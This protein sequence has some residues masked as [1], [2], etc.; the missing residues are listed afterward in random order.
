MERID[1]RTRNSD[2][3]MTS[4]GE[5]FKE[6]V[7]VLETHGKTSLLTGTDQGEPIRQVTRDESPRGTIQRDPRDGKG[8]EEKAHYTQ[9]QTSY[10]GEDSDRSGTDGGKRMEE[11]SSSPTKS[12]PTA[13]Q[14]LSHLSGT[15]EEEVFISSTIVHSLHGMSESERAPTTAI[16]S[17][18][19][20][21][22][23]KA[24][25]VWNW[26]YP[27]ETVLRNYPWEQ[28]S[29]VGL[30]VVDFLKSAAL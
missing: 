13:G 21:T 11:Y 8:L 10:L 24:A 17:R 15:K 20:A 14:K 5:N 29:G 2:A 25:G 6:N 16:Q 7:A 3:E 27:K 28:M 26:D 18:L 9:R 1:C 12:S 30:I 22:V 4:D 23:L 19:S